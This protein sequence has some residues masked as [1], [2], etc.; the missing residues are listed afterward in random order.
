M[1]R[2]FT[3]LL[4]IALPASALAQSPVVVPTAAP[5]IVQ[6]S[7][8]TEWWNSTRTA[9]SNGARV[10][11]SFPLWSTPDGRILAI[12]ASAGNSGAPV[13]PQSPQIGTAIDW[14]LV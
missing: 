7:S 13:A 2:L 1:R 9:P 6:V 5:E 14:R 8:P 11:G 12:V 10:L 4:S 3:L